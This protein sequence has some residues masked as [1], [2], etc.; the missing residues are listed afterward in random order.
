MAQ[1]DRLLVNLQNFKQSPLLAGQTIRQGYGLQL[2]DNLAP[3]AYPLVMGLYQSG[4]G[5]RLPR[6]DGSSE[7]FLYLTTIQ[8]AH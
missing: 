5:Q 2:P 1:N 3:G 7:D 8:V 4:S 6:T